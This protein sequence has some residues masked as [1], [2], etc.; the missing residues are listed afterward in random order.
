M[1]TVAGLI[2]AA[3]RASRMGSDKRLAR[4]GG[5]SMLELAMA[6]AMGAGLDPVVVVVSGPEPLAPMPRGISVVIN[7]E[8]SRGMASSL[9]TGV[10]ALP[11]SVAGVAVLLADMPRVE[12]RH[13]L[14]LL[15]QAGPDRICVP[16]HQGRRGN[17]VVLGRTFFPDLL[18]LTGDRGAKG[19]LARH[20]QAVREVEMPDES[21]L[22]D[23]DT[24]EELRA[25]GGEP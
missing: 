5:H 7:P 17:P 23:V 6:A 25:A 14:L 9:V 15:A 13:L 20:S 12:A 1:K 4:I 18:A 2:L 10:E 8:P 21:V 24:P 3:G 11:D 19:I 22:M 16:V